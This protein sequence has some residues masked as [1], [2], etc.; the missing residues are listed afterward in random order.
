MKEGKI[1]Y[2]SSEKYYL[3]D[4]IRQNKDLFHNTLTNYKE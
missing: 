3:K 1:A 4:E 2:F